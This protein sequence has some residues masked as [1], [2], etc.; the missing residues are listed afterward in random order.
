MFKFAVLKPVYS[1]GDD[2]GYTVRVAWKTVKIVKAWDEWDAVK[3]AKRAG[4]YAPV[5]ERIDNV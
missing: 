2:K 3:K 4:I 1:N 5:V